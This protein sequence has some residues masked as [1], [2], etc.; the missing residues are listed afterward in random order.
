MKRVIVLGRGGAGKSTLSRELA[1]KLQL[2]V[3]ELDKMFWD[4]D[5]KPMSLKE[6]SRLQEDIVKDATWVADSVRG[7]GLRTT[8]PI[9]RY[10]IV[11]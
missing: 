6:W 10:A 4:A 7:R 3:H 2:P 8:F 11:P 1:G 5:L 9:K